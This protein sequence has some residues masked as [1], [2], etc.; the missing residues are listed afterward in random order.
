MSI[1][2]KNILF[3]AEETL[4]TLEER[5]VKNPWLWLQGRK[6]RTRLQINIK[7]LCSQVTQVKKTNIFVQLL[8]FFLVKW[9]GLQVDLQRNSQ[10][11]PKSETLIT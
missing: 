1:C 2:L 8:L 7:D 5:N 4:I 11:R 6:K 3:Q 9:G 10:R